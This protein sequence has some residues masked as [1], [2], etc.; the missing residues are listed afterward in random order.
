MSDGRF[1]IGMTPTRPV[2]AAPQIKIGQEGAV[3]SVEPAAAGDLT[4]WRDRFLQAFGTSEP[5]IA[6]ALFNQLIN[7]LHTDPKEPLSASTANLALA[8]L[9]RLAPRNELE[10]ML[11]VQLIVAHVASMDTSRRGLHA[12]QSVGGRQAYLGLARKLMAL[13]TTQVE[14]LN[15]LRGN[16]VVQ[17]VVVERVNIEAGGKALVGAVSR[18][19]GGP[20]DA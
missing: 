10:G 19:S 3:E 17:R 20:E 7:A 1:P 16:T 11:C 15:R 4:A 5:A 2:I 6:E 8:L 18:R 13:F 14:T 9:H 12:D